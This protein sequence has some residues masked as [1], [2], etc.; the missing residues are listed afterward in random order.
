MIRSM[1]GFGDARQEL[2]GA[3]YTVEVRSVNHRYLKVAVRLPE[4]LAPL[5]GPIEEQVKGLVQR[6]SVTVRCAAELTEA[7][8]TPTIDQDALEAYLRAI[9]QAALRAG[10]HPSDLSHPTIDMA[11]L[12]QL[13]GVLRTP[14]QDARLRQARQAFSQLLTQ[15][16]QKMID[17]RQREGAALHQELVALCQQVKDALHTIAEHAPQVSAQY[18]QRLRARIEQLLPDAEPIDIVREVAAY[19]ERC[20]VNE[21]ISRLDGHVQQFLATLQR[22]GPVGRTLDF[23]AQEMLREANTIAS[24]SP[25]ATLSRAAIDAKAAIDRI[26]EQVQNVE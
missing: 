10:Q 22:D 12:L 18:E 17:M 5:E 19:A 9:H 7:L 26:K 2:G 24:K 15:A 21:E 16:C 13:P 1:T 11:G 4:D 6:G 14:S 20:D 23:I 25:D 3:T 8:P